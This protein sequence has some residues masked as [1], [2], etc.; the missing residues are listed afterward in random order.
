MRNTACPLYRACLDCAA[1]EDRPGWNCDGCRF[2]ED[3]SGSTLL[4]FEGCLLLL[5]AL[6]KPD[7]FE[8]IRAAE[9]ENRLRS[10]AEN[11]RLDF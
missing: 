9:N 11:A 4:D 7:L 8:R 2:Q 1:L 3:R 5:W 10:M 6:F